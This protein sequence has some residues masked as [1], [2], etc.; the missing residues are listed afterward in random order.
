MSEPHTFTRAVRA[1]F[2][3]YASARTVEALRLESIRAGIIARDGRMPYQAGPPVSPL[4][5]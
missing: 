3:R 5:S 4:H 2:G 1:V